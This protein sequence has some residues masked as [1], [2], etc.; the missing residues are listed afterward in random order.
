MEKKSKEVKMN[1]S[2]QPEKMTYEQLEQIAGNLNQQCRVLQQQL[3]Q[4]KNTIAEFNEIGMLLEV[5]KQSEQFTS[6]FVERCANKIEEL[7]TQALDE[8][9]KPQE[10]EKN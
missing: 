10:P 8:S 5:L 6:Q 4:A 1:E 3:I 7:I 2:K 9:E